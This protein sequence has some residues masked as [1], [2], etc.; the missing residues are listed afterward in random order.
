MK[1]PLASPDGSVDQLLGVATDITLR[2]QA[3]IEMQRAKEAAEAATEAKTVFLANMSHE[4]RT[5]MNGVLGMTELVLDTELQPE[6][7]EYLEM[8]KS[9]ADS[10]LTVIN[11]VLD[12][13]KIESGQIAFELRDID[14]RETVAATVKTF[15]VHASQKR[16]DL[17]CDIDEAVPDRL[18][19]DAHRLRQVLMNLIG[20]ALKFTHAGGVTVRVS[21]QE[22][23]SPG[24]RRVTAARR[25]HRHRHRH[26]RRQASAHL[27]TVPA[28]GRIDDAQ[29]RRHRPGPEHFV[30]AG[31]RHGRPP[32]GAEP[33]GARQRLPFHDRARQSPRR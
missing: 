26:S 7:R 23:L 8:A 15:M 18:V 30:P 5:P 3:T 13:S 28:G 2:K 25:G 11:D 16:L 31:G 21:L 27:R 1:I 29:V 12:F 4:I 10:L 14:L 32:L 9:S 20:N 22:P 19:A 33:G 6:Q 24:A 17:R